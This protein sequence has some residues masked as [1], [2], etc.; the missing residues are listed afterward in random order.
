MDGYRGQTHVL[1]ELDLNTGEAI[2]T[3]VVGYRDYDF[4][5]LAYYDGKVYLGRHNSTSI[6]VWDVEAGVKVKDLSTTYPCGGGLTGAD[7]L[8]VLFDSNGSW[9]RSFPSIQ[10]RARQDCQGSGRESVDVRRAGLP[11]R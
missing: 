2:K 8:G 1:Y 10:K 6:V 4:S 3:H 5:G 7:A 9:A 11:R